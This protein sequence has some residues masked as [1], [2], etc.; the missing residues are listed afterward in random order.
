VTLRQQKIDSQRTSSATSVS[1]RSSLL[2]C[3]AQK[4]LLRDHTTAP[5]HNWLCPIDFCILKTC[6]EQS[7]KTSRIIK[8]QTS[9]PLH[10]LKKNEKDATRQNSNHQTI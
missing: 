1:M 6:A 10:F 7:Q 4:L 2:R 8:I 5:M 9:C 3:P